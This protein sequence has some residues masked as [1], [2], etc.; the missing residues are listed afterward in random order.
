MCSKSIKQRIA[1]L[2]DK[3]NGHRVAAARSDRY[4]E[5]FHNNRQAR[6]L[7]LD[8]LRLER[9][10]ENANS[11]NVINQKTPELA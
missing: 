11:V 3:A 5:Y 1:D 8:A 9:E 10:Y 7:T 6:I 4:H 2:R